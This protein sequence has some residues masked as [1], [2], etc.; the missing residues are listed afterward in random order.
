MLRSVRSRVRL[1]ILAS[2]CWQC[3]EQPLPSP[4]SSAASGA[5]GSA[6]TGTPTAPAGG[7]ESGGSG[8]A[9]GPAPGGGSGGGGASGGAGS[10]SVAGSS[11]GGSDAGAAGEA[12]ISAEPRATRLGESK[13]TSAGLSLVS[14]GGYLNGESFQQDGILTHQGYQYAAFW[15]TA[16]HVV[17]ARRK[18]PSGAWQS[19][20]LSDYV[21]TESDAHNTISLGVTAA[22]GTLHVSFDHHSSPLHYRRSVAGLLTA[23]ETVAW[24]AASFDAVTSSLGGAAVTDF[25]YP[26]FVSVP[27]GEKTLLSARIGT[28]GS[29]DEYLWEYSGATRQWSARGKYIDGQVDNINAYLHGLTYGPGAKRLHAAWCWRDTSNASTNHDLLYAYSDDDGRT[30][31]NDVGVAIASTGTSAISS[32]TAGLVVSPIGQNRGLINQ[33]HL[34]VDAAGRVHVLLS[35]LPEGSAD[36]ANF[37]SA[38]GKSRYFHYVREAA[39]VWTRTALEQPTVAAFRGKLALSSSGN[40]YA[41]LPD[42][43]V[44][45]SAATP[46][47]AWQ[48]LHAGEPSRFFSDPLVDATRLQAEN[49]LSVVYPTRGS[50]DIFVVDFAVE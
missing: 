39:G 33:E 41:V 20:E 35:H 9:G 12:P 50:G 5:G 14:Y 48:L 24:T 22:D 27:G 49:V 46:P 17:L 29:G 37:D 19:L 45:G 38:R 3:S 26:R 43:R 4:P 16:R 1:G 7:S 44:A 31:H 18:L 11:P 6:G 40:L 8:S 25:T 10:A 15:N 21:N 13:L 2:L 47:A 32:K 36:D 34:T 30:W 23:P 42:L 28:S